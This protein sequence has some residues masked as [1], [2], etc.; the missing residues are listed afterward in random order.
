MSILD[1]HNKY[2]EISREIDN[3]VKIMPVGLSLE[4]QI[5]K[6]SANILR[7]YNVSLCISKDEDLSS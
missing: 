3:L 1:P 5:L 7:G 6:M 2:E 4:K